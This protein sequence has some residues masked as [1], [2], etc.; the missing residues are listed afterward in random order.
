[1]R[2]WMV[3]LIAIARHWVKTDDAT[4][5]ALRKIQ[6]K[7]GS[8]PGGLVVKNRRALGQFDDPNSTPE[9]LQFGPH[10]GGQ[11]QPIVGVLQLHVVFPV[12]SRARTP[13]CLR[14]FPP[15]LPGSPAVAW[16]HGCR[17]S[18]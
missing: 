14:T 7:L 16:G 4:L 10:P 9:R 13:C 17:S 3:H 1:M 18:V 12:L 15:S 6:G 2:G 8:Q 5:D 11:F